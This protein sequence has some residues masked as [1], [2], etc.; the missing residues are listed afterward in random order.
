MHDT[1][2]KLVSKSIPKQKSQIII[3]DIFG[4]FDKAKEKSICVS[5]NKTL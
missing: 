1:R 2:L 3:Y 5:G 4:T